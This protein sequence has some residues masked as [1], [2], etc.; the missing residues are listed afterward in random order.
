MEGQI[1]AGTADL[2]DHEDPG[3]QFASD[4]RHWIVIYRERIALYSDL[5]E[6]AR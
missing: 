6:R 5:L 3:T 2:L 4:A 1:D